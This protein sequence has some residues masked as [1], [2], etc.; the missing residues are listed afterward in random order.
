[1]TFEFAGFLGN[2]HL[3]DQEKMIISRRERYS[4]KYSLSSPI[5]ERIYGSWFLVP[6]VVGCS[7]T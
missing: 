7:K 1:M 5:M 4:S 6:R 2:F 3:G